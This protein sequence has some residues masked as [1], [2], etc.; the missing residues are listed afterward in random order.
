MSVFG[1]SLVF[2][3]SLLGLAILQSQPRPK[4]ES[5]SLHT[6]QVVHQ[7][8]GQLEEAE[9]EAD[10]KNLMYGLAVGLMAGPPHLQN[11]LL[12]ILIQNCN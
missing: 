8:L 1:V 7:L 12:M 5:S 10:Q 9:P 6:Y 3:F 2:H 11:D 4:T